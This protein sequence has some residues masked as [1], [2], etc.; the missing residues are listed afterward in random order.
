MSDLLLL[1]SLKPI[2]FGLIGMILSGLAFPITGV[3][4][5][6]NNLIPI[7]YMLMH[8]IIL[9]GIFSIAF[10]L[11]LLP[12]VIVLNIILVVLMLLFNKDK[13]N[14]LGTAST[15][16]MVITMGLASLLSHIF[17]VPS[18]DTLE[19]LWGSPFALTKTDLLI[20]GILTILIFFYIFKFFMP[21]SMCFFDKEI[22]KSCG[23]NVTLHN[24]L[25][26]F[27]VA[28]IVSV[29]MKMVGA[30]LIDALVILP[31]LAAN[32][33]AKSLKSL[34]IRSSIFG[35]IL[36]TGGYFVSLLTN[37]PVSGIIAVLTTGLY[38]IE[39]FINYINKKR[40]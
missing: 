23:V 8:G 5:L 39:K 33:R 4:I 21:I 2:Y 38:L 22:A 6:K 25:M 17:D 18:K 26:I 34:F 37:L 9:G 11:P 29:A 36:S 28:L 24:S 35:F 1:L 7:R 31:V 12:L 14:S 3:I 19:L 13:K 16:M 20:L 30:L 27:F 10:N 32:Q 15:A 40:Y